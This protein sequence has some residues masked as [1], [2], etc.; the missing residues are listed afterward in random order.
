MSITKSLYTITM[1]IR[2][3]RCNKCGYEWE[4]RK[5]NPKECPRCKTR[6]DINEKNN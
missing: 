4:A 6:L 1:M 2:T 3:M 5:D